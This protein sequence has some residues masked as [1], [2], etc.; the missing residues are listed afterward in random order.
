MHRACIWA[1]QIMHQINF[2]SSNHFWSLLCIYSSYLSFKF[3]FKKLKTHVLQGIEHHGLTSKSC[4]QSFISSKIRLQYQTLSICLTS[5]AGQNSNGQSVTDNEVH[6]KYD[7]Q[8][9]TRYSR[10]AFG[11]LR[12]CIRSIFEA[13]TIFGAYYVYITQDS[14][15]NSKMKTHVL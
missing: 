3:K 6:D 5:T 11:S 12:S 8:P 1:T 14:S 10:L 4:W 13:Q 15:L 7:I 2:R 9:E